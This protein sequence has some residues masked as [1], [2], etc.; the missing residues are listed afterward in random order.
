MIFDNLNNYIGAKPTGAGYNLK[1]PKKFLCD[2]NLLA[3]TKKYMLIYMNNLKHLKINDEF[4]TEI[5]FGDFINEYMTNII[6]IEHSEL[7]EYK[8]IL[9]KTAEDDN[10]Y[11]VSLYRNT[12]IFS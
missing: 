3:K 7:N 1:T 2:L 6:Y 9:L 4:I 11:T 10:A 12:L 8:F 5:E